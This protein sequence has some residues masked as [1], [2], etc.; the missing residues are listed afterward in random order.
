MTTTGDV[1]APGESA[2]LGDPDLASA[3]CG[4]GCR[5]EGGGPKRVKWLRIGLASSSSWWSSVSRG[6]VFRQFGHGKTE[7]S[8]PGR[9]VGIGA[10]G[11]PNYVEVDARIGKIDP[12]NN[13]VTVRL[14][15]IPHGKYAINIWALAQSMIMEVDG[16]AGGH[17]SYNAQQS[18]EPVDASMELHRQSQPV[19]I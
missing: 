6:I 7:I 9:Y 2:P 1:E 14:D 5:P 17:V 11:T 10:S 16:V 4:R 15:V 3:D 18:P 8:C 13:Q 12:L 19:P